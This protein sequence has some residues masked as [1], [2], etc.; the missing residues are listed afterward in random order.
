MNILDLPMQQ[1]DAKAATIREYLKALL[2][3]VWER[4]ES[5]S[6]KRPFG[7]SGWK[8]EVYAA[9]IKAGAVT[10]R[11]DDEG[12]VEECEDGEADF[13]IAKAITSLQ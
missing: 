8:S 5:F 3:A 10:G 4:D 7:N 2:A 12:C 9:L 1:N 6:G 11:L 13:L